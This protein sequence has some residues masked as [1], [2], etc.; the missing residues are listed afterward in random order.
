MLQGY[1]LFSLRAAGHEPRVAMDRAAHFLADLDLEAQA[2]NLVGE[3]SGGQQD[4]VIAARCDRVVEIHAGRV[5]D[6]TAVEQD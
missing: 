4:P 6:N 3:L 1:G 5:T 2:D